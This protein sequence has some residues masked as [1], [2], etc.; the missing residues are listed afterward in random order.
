MWAGLG[1][2]RYVPD[3]WVRQE[4]LTDLAKDD[5][6]ALNAHLVNLLKATDSAFSIGNF[7]SLFCFFFIKLI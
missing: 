7:F 4:P 5:I 3:I 2:V 1:G 6:N